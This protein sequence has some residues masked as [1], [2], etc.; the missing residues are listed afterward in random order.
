MVVMKPSTTTLAPHSA[1][2]AVGDDVSIMVIALALSV[3]AVGWFELRVH[4]YCSTSFL[5]CATYF[6]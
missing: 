1:Q 6:L 3:V 5:M 4:A 2:N